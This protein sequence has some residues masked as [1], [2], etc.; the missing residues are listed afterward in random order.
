[1]KK[2]SLWIWRARLEGRVAGPSRRGEQ[3][4][5]PTPGTVT[6]LV[7]AQT[8]LSVKHKGNYLMCHCTRSQRIPRHTAQNLP[9]LSEANPAMGP[10]TVCWGGRFKGDFAYQHLGLNFKGPSQ[11]KCQGE[12]FLLL[13]KHLFIFIK[14]N[15]FWFKWCWYVV[16]QVIKK[17]KR[18][19][20]PFL[21]M[22]HSV[23]ALW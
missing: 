9:Q 10:Y 18:N 2:A 3:P 17:K 14:I 7:R 1:M 23:I 15:Q 21:F 4:G 11:S 5:D 20:K 13:L 12:T 8:G 19:K 6:C 16:F 22:P